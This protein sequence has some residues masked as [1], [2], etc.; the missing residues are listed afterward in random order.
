ML[1]FADIRAIVS[2]LDSRV[3]GGQVQKVQAL[4]A[5]TLWLRVRRPGATVH[6]V[7]SCHP[8]AA[9]LSEAEARDAVAR[10]PSA[11][12]EGPVAMALVDWLRSVAGG[13]RLRAVEVV[14]GERTVM[15]R[16]DEGT[17]VA[18]LRGRHS[19][20]YG[21]A[22]DGRIAAW[23]RMPTGDLRALH[24]GG[25]YQPPLRNDPSALREVPRGAPTFAL[26]RDVE[27]AA[28]E[29]LTSASSRAV[30]SARTKLLTQTR[31]RLRRLCAK[32]R[33]D[34]E[35]FANAEDWRRRGE[36]LKGQMYALERAGRGAE[37]VEVQDWYTQGAA[38]V[39]VP[40]DPTLGPRANVDKC[41]RLY[42]RAKTGSDRAGM[43]L[44]EVE[45]QLAEVERIADM[46]SSYDDTRSA[47]ASA[48]L[49]RR[50]PPG[51]GRRRVEAP[52][53]PFRPFV[54]RAGER[55]LVG[56]GGADN[57]ALTFRVA[58]GN[59]HWLHV[60]DAAGAHVVVPLPT[61]GREPHPETLIDAAAL[62][63]HHSKL[64]G[65][66]AADVTHTRR[67]H[68][69]AVAGGPP[70]RVFVADA[71][72]IHVADIAARIERLYR[73]AAMD[74]IMQV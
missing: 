29:R 16:F 53:T 60:R 22:R 51:P 44:V 26:A 4:D 3:V 46:T 48:G 20:L 67:K 10:A 7:L 35:R 57:H 12:G 58:R 9:R 13:R 69:R 68:V 65:E 66:G 31:K 71:R 62:A 11:E 50:P 43:R 64:R 61:R 72:A 34:G 19:N 38:P 40:I 25:I 2:D 45:A 15:L 27:V 39:T 55:V 74:E 17:L 49:L 56:R 14:D 5:W 59:D 41:F 21:V 24:L 33:A 18:E 37:S 28:A 70:G 42:R 52:R 47:L 23:A 32:V 1:D 73:D 63:V 54:S 30:E 36:L 6:L 8:D